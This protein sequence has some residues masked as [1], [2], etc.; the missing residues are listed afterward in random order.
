VAAADRAARNRKRGR[1]MNHAP[2]DRAQRF[3]A[4]MCHRAATLPLGGVSIKH[5][6]RDPSD[7]KLEK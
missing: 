1:E 3:G 2:R 4:C 6:T 7:K 5:F